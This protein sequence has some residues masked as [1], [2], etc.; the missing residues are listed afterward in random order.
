MCDAKAA[1]GGPSPISLDDIEEASNEFNAA[2]GR[3]FAAW[4]I[5]ETILDKLLVRMTGAPPE[6]SAAMYYS[7]RSFN[8]KADMI[9]AVIHLVSAD[10]NF[11]SM[12]KNIMKKVRQYSSTRNILAH[13]HQSSTVDISSD[14]NKL[15]LHYYIRDAS[16]MELP[17]GDDHTTKGQL[18]NCRENFGRLAYYILYTIKVPA[19][20]VRAWPEKCLE[21]L[22]QL[23]IDACSTSVAPTVEVPAIPP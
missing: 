18:E 4:A 20:E 2:Y 1:E 7:T 10:E 22:R 23:P 12:L 9:E 16:K 15:N 11:K 3:A 13:A 5:V 21:L 6:M 17:L 14:G 19:A 8:A